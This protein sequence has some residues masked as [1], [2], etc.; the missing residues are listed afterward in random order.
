[1]KWKAYIE[2]SFIG[3]IKVRKTFIVQCVVSDVRRHID[4]RIRMLL[5]KASAD[6]TAVVDDID[7]ATLVSTMQTLWF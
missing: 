3:K 7:L 2:K 1:M 4:Q 5:L 6:D